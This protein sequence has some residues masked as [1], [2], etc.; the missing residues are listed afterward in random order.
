MDGG[1]VVLA[2][3]IQGDSEGREGKRRLLMGGNVLDLLGAR[4]DVGD[5]I[6]HR[7]GSLHEKGHVLDHRIGE[8]GRGMVA[9]LVEAP[10]V[11]GLG[12][13]EHHHDLLKV[14][15]AADLAAVVAGACFTAHLSSPR[16]QALA[17]SLGTLLEKV[18]VGPRQAA[19]KLGSGMVEELGE[20]QAPIVAVDTGDVG[21]G[22]LPPVVHVVGPPVVGH[23]ELDVGGDLLGSHE[24]VGSLGG[25]QHWPEH[26]LH[27]TGESLPFIEDNQE[28]AIPEDGDGR[29]LV[30][31]D[32]NAEVFH[33][34]DM[35]DGLGADD[36]LLM[37]TV[38]IGNDNAAF[39][40]GVSGLGP[41]HNLLGDAVGGGEDE[42]HRGLPPSGP[43][44]EGD[45][46]FR[47][48]G[49]ASGG[50]DS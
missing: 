44:S 13:W 8:A 41:A 15:R 11:G 30:R 9:E 49:K 47:V 16:I 32:R 21:L 23:H 31:R 43:S 48:G 19:S 6:G 3:L 2:S 12:G 39:A 42:G 24:S 4:A 37:E 1:G 34:A 7:E 14:P 18:E 36:S 38:I 35:V 22:Q 20:S 45:G 25:F 46:G 28:R 29:G 5:D 26:L 27:C 50:R 10:A 17:L 33:S 40:L